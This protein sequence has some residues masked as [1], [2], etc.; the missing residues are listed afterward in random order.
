MV[1]GVC[2]QTGFR[3]NVDCSRTLLIRTHNAPGAL[4]RLQQNGNQRM[5][6]MHIIYEANAVISTEA[7]TSSLFLLSTIYAGGFVR[8]RGR[9]R[10]VCGWLDTNRE[11]T[12]L[13]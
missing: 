6:S 8:S 7:E 9:D 2:G 10:G 13:N 11:L 5:L 4:A 1:K 12:S 3:L